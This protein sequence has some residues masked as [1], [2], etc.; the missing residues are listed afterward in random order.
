MN[1]LP[2]LQ[3]NRL[4]GWRSTTVERNQGKR[5]GLVIVITCRVVCGIAPTRASEG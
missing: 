3:A 4:A 5:S 1:D 2:S